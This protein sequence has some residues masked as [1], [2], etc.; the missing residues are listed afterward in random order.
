MM[1]WLKQ[2]DG[3]AMV[4]RYNQQLK[5]IE[6]GNGDLQV[7]LELITVFDEIESL[8]HKRINIIV[9]N[10]PRRCQDRKC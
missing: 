6:Q 7:P 5:E 1:V 9:S 10:T 8:V 4:K 2:E 3:A